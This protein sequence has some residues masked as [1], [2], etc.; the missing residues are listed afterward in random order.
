M[1]EQSGRNFKIISNDVAD[2]FITINPIFLKPFNGADLKALYKALEQKQS[3]VRSEPFPYNNIPLIRKRN[4]RLQ[5]LYSS[6]LII[7][8]YAREKNIL[9]F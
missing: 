8:N 9:M 2:G 4:M 1:P 7:R 5:R 3:E 6:L